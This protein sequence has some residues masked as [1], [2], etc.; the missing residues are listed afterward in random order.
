MHQA[1]DYPKEIGCR[2]L[3]LNSLP[4]S[5]EFY[6]KCNFKQLKREEKRREK[7]MYS[8]I[9]KELCKSKNLL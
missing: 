3:V 4:S 6:T 7:V 8:V 5:V 1:L 9:S 2:L